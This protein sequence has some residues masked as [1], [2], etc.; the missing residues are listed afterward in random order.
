M[1]QLRSSEFLRPFKFCC[2]ENKQMTKKD[3]NGIIVVKKKLS[4]HIDKWGNSDLY[5]LQFRSVKEAVNAISGDDNIL[6]KLITEQLDSY[7]PIQN[8]WITRY[9]ETEVVR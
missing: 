1:V 4:F 9:F 3:E 6:R 2:L 8:H 5:D 7:K